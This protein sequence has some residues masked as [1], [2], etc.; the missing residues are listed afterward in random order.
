MFKEK[1]L[2]DG[3]NSGQV[4]GAGL[5]VFTE[6]PP[7]NLELIKHPRVSCTPHLGASTIE[8]QNRV[9]SEI[10]SQIIDSMVAM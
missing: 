3:L 8:A 9:S 1:A 10:A 7:R 5:D 6:E 2:L 4:G